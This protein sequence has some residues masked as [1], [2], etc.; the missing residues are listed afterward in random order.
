MLHARR[1]GLVLLPHAALLLWL[2]ALAAPAA[3]SAGR[4]DPVPVLSSAQAER[5]DTL[6]IRD[7]RG[8]T[9]M[10]SG[11]ILAATL[12]EVLIE[13][14]GKERSVASDRVVRLTIGEVPAGYEEGQRLLQSGDYANAVSSFRLVAADGGASKVVQAA[15]GALALEAG[16]RLAGRGEGDFAAL[17]IDA[18][19]FTASQSDSRELP[20]I[21]SLEARALWL[22]NQAGE[23]GKRYE[24]L[25]GE[26][27][28]ATTNPGYDLVECL[29]SGWLGS[30]A[31]LD[32]GDV[33][34][35]R[36]LAKALET[37]LPAAL[38][39]LAADDPRRGRLEALAQGASQ[40]EGFAL[41]ADKK[42]SQAKTFFKSAVDG[43][44]PSDLLQRTVALVGLGESHA[45]QGEWREA[46]V[47]FAR[48]FAT[49]A[50]QPEFLGRA[51][52][53]QAWCA[54]ELAESNSKEQ[55][56]RWLDSLGRL[57]GTTPA[58]RRGL[59]LAK[60]L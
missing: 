42:A 53:G 60:R 46:R 16:L 30:L 24:A 1:S 33:A 10:L 41:L 31:K 26:L 18:G 15:A 13:V 22:S 14:D 52:A 34:G 55:A 50:D 28:G 38:A 17:A 29:R 37:A 47:A 12:R 21:R 7:A 27:Q 35:A 6:M 54:L 4:F 45:A 43:A 11:R 32:A 5:P 48:A 25:F 57:Y 2:A 49:G 44:K 19:R 9:S 20:A 40:L 56:R 39:E 59:E 8:G 58:S 3:A 23:A 51:L 36:K